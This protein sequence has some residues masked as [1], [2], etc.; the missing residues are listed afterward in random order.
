MLILCIWCCYCCCCWFYYI[1][2]NIDEQ[3][4]WSLLLLP[5]KM[6]VDSMISISNCGNGFSSVK[7]CLRKFRFTFRQKETRK[8]AYVCLCLF[9]FVC[10]LKKYRLW[11]FIFMQFSPVIKC[12]YGQKVWAENLCEDTIAHFKTNSVTTRRKNPDNAKN[13]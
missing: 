1:I 3:F 7:K 6:D 12:F 13:H 4:Y 11:I 2:V 10:S 5:N 8:T 9:V